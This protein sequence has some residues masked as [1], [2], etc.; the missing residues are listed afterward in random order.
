MSSRILLALFVGTMMSVVTAQASPAGDERDPEKTEVNSYG[1]D[2]AHSSISF[3]V[4]HLGLANVTGAFRFYEVDLVMNP[5]DLSTLRTEAVVQ[6]ESID[7]GIEKRDN[8]L[9]S[10]DFFEAAVYPTIKFVS[11]EVRKIDGSEFELVGD[12]TIRDITREV[13]LEAEVVGTAVGPMGETRIGLEASGEI[14]RKDFGLTWNNLT[15]AGGIIVGDKV[16]M[17]L[18]VQAI[19][20]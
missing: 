1:I 9:R 13:V 7:T 12:L 15:E 6:V 2:T 17:V 10:A 11:R 3:K 16:K 14:S 5:N 4:R 20:S 19:Q 18:E 8:H